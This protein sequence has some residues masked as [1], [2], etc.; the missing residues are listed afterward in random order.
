MIRTMAIVVLVLSL[1]GPA[2]AQMTGNDLRSMCVSKNPAEDDLCIS[3]SAGFHSGIRAAQ[4]IAEIVKLPPVTCIPD[5][6]T[7][8][9]VRLILE[10]Y[11]RENPQELAQGA[12]YLAARAFLQSFPC[13][14]R[15]P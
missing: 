9:Q 1:V 3:W 14:P 10:K 12:D 2:R 4:K 15:K 11:M 5:N 7:G 13:A 8:S 6:V